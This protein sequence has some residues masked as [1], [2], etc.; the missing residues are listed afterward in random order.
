MKYIIKG[1]EPSELT[2][3]KLKDKMYQRGKPD[4]NRLKKEVK[5]A[6]RN[7][8]SKEQGYICCYC[9]RRITE[10]NFHLEHLKPKA[11][12]KFP[13]LQLEYSNLL[14]SCQLDLEQGEPRHCGN[15]KGSWYDEENFVS[16]LDPDCTG[17][18]KFTA[19]GQIY[20]ADENDEAIQTTIEK[21]RLDIDK[22][23]NL[24]KDAI[25]PFL[26]LDGYLSEEDLKQFIQGYLVDKTAN[27]GMYNEFY[28]TI[29]YLFDNN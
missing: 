22:L 16:P 8:I 19:N 20:S 1:T 27:N 11:E 29:K 2:D 24:R 18:F 15:I 13:Q 5:D 26:N 28:T 9:E 17:R 7:T 6:L 4:W 12:S 10:N 21:L 23:N 3:W 14:C 25:E